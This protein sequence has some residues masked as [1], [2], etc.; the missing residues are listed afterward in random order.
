MMRSPLHSLTCLLKKC[1]KMSRKKFLKYGL[2]MNKMSSKTQLSK[3]PKDL[4]SVIMIGWTLVQKILW[5][6]STL[7]NPQQVS[8]NQS[9]FINLTSVKKEWNKNKFLD[10]KVSGMM[11]NKLINSKNNKIKKTRNGESHGKNFLK[12]KI[13]QL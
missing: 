8:L 7:L 2:M 10:L 11:K 5:F 9:K 13:L 4:P 1:W 3:L 6:S 12:I